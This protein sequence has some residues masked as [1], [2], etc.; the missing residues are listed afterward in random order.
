MF[1][2]LSVNV[3]LGSIKV[4]QIGNADLLKLGSQI[5]PFRNVS[6]EKIVLNIQVERVISAISHTH[7]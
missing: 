6:R 4:C 1:H 3:S 7:L 5:G 2:R